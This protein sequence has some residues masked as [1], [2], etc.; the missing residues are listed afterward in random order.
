MLRLR[1]GVLLIVISWLPFAQLFLW[2]AHNNGKL[3]TEQAST[4]FR[5]S[6]WAIQILIGFVGVWLVGKLA[7]QTARQNGIKKV[8]GELWRL[9]KTGETV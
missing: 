9:F 3:Q 2:V 5:L 8:P 7:V 4:Q 1:I 6:V